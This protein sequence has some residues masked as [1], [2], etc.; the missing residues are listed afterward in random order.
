[1]GVGGQPQDPAALPPGKTR[2]LLREAENKLVRS[3][4]N[5]MTDL[6]VISRRQAVGIMT[7]MTYIVTECLEIT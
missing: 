5:T 1:M 6:H 7:G 4:N 3:I 2:Y